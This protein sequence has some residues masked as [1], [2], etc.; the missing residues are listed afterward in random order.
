[1]GESQ[2]KTVDV[3]LCTADH[4]IV[5]GGD[6]VNNLAARHAA[7]RAVQPRTFGTIQGRVGLLLGIAAAMSGVVSPI[8]AVSIRPAMLLVLLGAIIGLSAGPRIRASG[9]GS[10]RVLGLDLMFAV[11]LLVITAAELLNAAELNYPVVLGALLQPLFWAVAYIGARSVIADLASAVPFLRGMVVPV[12]VVVPIGLGQALGIAP[13]V[14][15]TRR[16]VAADGYGDRVDD[17]RLLRAVG[18]IGNWTS[19]GSYLTAMCAVAVIL[20]AIATQRRIG[21][22]P[23]AA[24]VLLVALFGTATT[25]TIAPIGVAACVVLFGM[26]MSRVAFR[27]GFIIGVVAIGALSF[28]GPALE[29]RVAEQSI[30]ASRVEWLPEWVPST[31][32]SR[33]AIWTSQTIPMIAERPYTGWGNNVYVDTNPMRKYPTSLIWQSAE[34]QYLYTAMT[35]G[36]VGLCALIL[37]LLAMIGLAIR[38]LKHEGVALVA[39]PVLILVLASVASA[40]MSP[41]FYSQGLTST[42]WP[43]LGVLAALVVAEVPPPRWA[44]THIDRSRAP[45]RVVI[46]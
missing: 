34:S 33:I 20:L 1:M 41:V 43:M 29:T 32:G 16:F 19:F 36:F 39:R 3:T 38:G 26:R 18:L 7:E 21:S 22:A 42:L 12:F 37:L 23:Y 17:G 45:E 31:I 25:L 11:Y 14:E 40:T 15:A 44:M 46:G 8:S 35:Y 6:R 4:R 30:A 28:L 5:R 2:E 24:A 27:N 10:A 13:I 9:M